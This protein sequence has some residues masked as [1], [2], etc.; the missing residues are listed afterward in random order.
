V[1]FLTE[2]KQISMTY[3]TKGYK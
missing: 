3:I 2:D 1:D